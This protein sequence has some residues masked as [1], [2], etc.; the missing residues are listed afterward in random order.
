VKYG[1]AIWVGHWEFI[2]SPYGFEDQPIASR[3]AQLRP[4]FLM[5]RINMD[6]IVVCPIHPCRFGIPYICDIINMILTRGSYQRGMFYVDKERER[7]SK[8]AV[9]RE[10]IER[11]EERD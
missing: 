1:D 11:G 8:S 9:A 10:E 4:L 6:P 5:L 2:V 7:E 3:R